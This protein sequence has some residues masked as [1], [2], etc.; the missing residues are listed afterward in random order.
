MRQWLISNGFQGGEGEQVPE[1]TD[2]V[3][4]S[5]SDRYKELFKSFTG[6]ELEVY[7]TQNINNRIEESIN[8][9]IKNVNF[10]SNLH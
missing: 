5:I 6:R 1:M 10:S 4:N 3:V 2:D 9:S 7:D 8:K